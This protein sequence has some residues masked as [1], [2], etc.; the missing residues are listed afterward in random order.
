MRPRRWWKI[1]LGI[2]LL[3]L[4]PL[5]YAAWPGSST[6]TVS[7]ETTYITE[8]L[9]KHGYPDYVTALNQRLS[10]GV[11]PE[12]NA[13]ALIWQAL[14][15]HPEGATMPAEY[16]QWLGYAPPEQG[17]YI[18]PFS[19]YLKENL[20]IEDNEKRQQLDDRRMRATKWPWAAKGEPE[21]ADWLRRHEKPLALVIEATNRP[22]Y[23]NPLVPTLTP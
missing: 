20:K 21:L 4:A 13:N 6:F 9:D 8:P 22:Q 12:N 7:P 17:E 1:A 14:G 16:F 2:L 5:V 11:T 19:K 18:V 23:Y 3:F 15:P 10:Q